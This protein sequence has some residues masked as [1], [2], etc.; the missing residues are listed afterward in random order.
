MPGGRPERAAQT[1]HQPTAP[2]SSTKVTAPA[3][4]AISA[5]ITASLQMRQFGRPAAGPP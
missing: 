3:E 2:V 5:A 1:S 4:P